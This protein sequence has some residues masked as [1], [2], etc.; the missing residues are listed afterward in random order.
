[1]SALSTGKFDIV[2]PILVVFAQMS[3]IGDSNPYGVVG[4]E[5]DN[6]KQLNSLLEQLRDET[7]KALQDLRDQEAKR[8]EDYTANV[9][10]L[11]EI[12]AKIDAET[13]EVRAHKL[14]MDS[15]MD[16][17]Q[18][19]MFAAQAKYKRNSGLWDSTKTMCDLFESEYN[20][21]EYA[22]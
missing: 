6:V 2:T 15:C 1:M 16:T 11:T 13:D 19:V 18:M 8:I 3:D 12:V 14:T 4:A 7:E 10:T 20:E 22:R 17:E 21:A 9:K 5:D